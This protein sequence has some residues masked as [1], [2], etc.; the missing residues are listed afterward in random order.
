MRLIEPL[1]DLFATRSHVRVLRALDGLP[2]G[3]GVSGREI[4]RRARVSHPTALQALNSL[5]DQGL[6]LVRRAPKV[7]FYRLNTEH[8]LVSPLRA[9]FARER[10]VP[11][12]LE[13]AIEASLRQI[14]DVKAA[15]MFGSAARGD[16]RVNSD[17]DVAAISGSPMPEEIS[18]LEP[19]YRRFG[20]RVNV[21]RLKRTGARGLKA[22]IAKDGK[23]LT[24]SPRRR[25][26]EPREG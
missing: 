6:L 15:Y 21:L 19:I 7:A 24:L 18:D 16:M 26:R 23:Q 3:V 25:N 2:E 10:A 12:D 4:A 20:N 13:T 14:R 11:H 1:N 17:I 22:Q 9:I 8:V 5:A